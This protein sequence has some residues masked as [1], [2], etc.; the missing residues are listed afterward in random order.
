MLPNR[1]RI[2]NQRSVLRGWRIGS[3]GLYVDKVI[4]VFRVDPFAAAIIHIEATVVGS[5]SWLDRR[6]VCSNHFGIGEL[7]CNVAR[8]QESVIRAWLHIS[9]PYIAQMPVPVPAKLSAMEGSDKAFCTN[10]GRGCSWD[11]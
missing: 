10:R 7:V 11:Y 5:H 4:I 3:L 8:E 1:P 9:I 6:K 2:W